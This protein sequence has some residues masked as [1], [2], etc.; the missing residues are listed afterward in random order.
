MPTATTTVYSTA[1]QADYSFVNDIIGQLKT[2]MTIDPSMTVISDNAPATGATSR[3][4][5]L[6]IHNSQ[7]YLEIQPYGI[8]GGYNPGGQ[9]PNVAAE[10]RI[11]A[12]DHATVIYDGYNYDYSCI[13]NNV[14][15]SIVYGANVFAFKALNS[16]NPGVGNIIGFQDSSGGFWISQEGVV[17]WLRDGDDTNRYNFDTYVVTRLSDDGNIILFPTMLIDP[18]TGRYYDSLTPNAVYAIDPGLSPSALQD[19]SIY[20]DNNGEYAYYLGNVLYHE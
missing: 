20:E 5:V 11:L 1:T 8:D 12:T 16:P 13:N 17:S 15:C 10:I 7:H 19:R 2:F 18:L 6:Q 3:V 4:V 9:S 14:T